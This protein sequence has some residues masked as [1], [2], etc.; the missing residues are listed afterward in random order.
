MKKIYQS[1]T[2]IT[3]FAIML[4]ICPIHT[5]G[6]QKVSGNE[7]TESDYAV[8][9]EVSP[10]ESEA[11]TTILY[12]G[13]DGDLSWSIDSSNHL[14]IQGTGDYK[15]RDPN[16]TKAGWL[17][18]KDIIATASV[19]VKDMTDASYMFSGCSKLTSIDFSMFETSRITKMRGMFFECSSLKSLDLQNFQ[20]GNVTSMSS[21]FTGCSAL[22]TLNVGGFDTT[23]VVYMYDMFKGC[24]KLT[25]LDVSNFKTENVVY[26]YGMFQECNSLSVLDVSGFNTRNVSYMYD[27][28]FNCKSLI[29]LDL[30]GF[31]LSSAEKIYSLIGCDSLMKVEVSANI[32]EEISLPAASGFVWMDEYG[33][34]CTKITPELTKSAVYT[35][36][37]LVDIN[38]ALIETIPV[39]AY[40]A[41]QVTPELV[42][43]YM[44]EKLE[45]G[46][47]Y[48]VEYS[49]NIFPGTAK[50]TVNGKGRYI[51]SRDVNFI[52]E[53]KLNKAKINTLEYDFQKGNLSKLTSKIY[54]SLYIDFVP[55]KFAAKYEIELVDK[56]KKKE[57][58]IIVDCTNKDY[59]YKTIKNLTGDVYTVRIRALVGD[60]KGS[61][62]DKVYV[63]KQP[64]AQAR[65]Y[66][67]NVQIKW[68]KISGATGYDIYMSTSRNGKYKKVAS[69]G[70]NTALKTIKKY[71]KKKLQS[72]KYYYYVVAKKKV[73]KKT[74]K[75]GKNFVYTIKNE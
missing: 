47:D 30:S 33:N 51:G 63:I 10:Q 15:Q 71:N 68:E 59:V 64:R 6:V 73:G 25:A 72:K 69:A 36:Y 20:T 50:I 28:F 44:G 5:Y 49:D 9:H 37:S 52:I 31:D 45:L 75:S 42:I 62:S 19:N 43:R 35:K 3:L 26:M 17:E 13:V 4:I 60:V 48:V 67:G 21:M 55:D 40:T 2:V 41:K 12:N 66:N 53:I 8:N 24:K 38:E 11:A 70:K 23:K 39:Q 16:T 57:K 46:R 74:Y 54:Y 65:T 32:L 1:I 29:E 14:T 22:E 7:M 18:Y 61:W 56:K 58:T 34:V 27:M